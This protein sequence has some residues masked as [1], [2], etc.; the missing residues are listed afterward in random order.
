MKSTVLLTLLLAGCSSPTA[1]S[2]TTEAS[3][4]ASP[5]SDADHA[6]CGDGTRDPEE[7]CDDGNT[8]S[9]DGCSAE[10]REERVGW[11][12]RL[13]P[14]APPQRYGSA[15]AFDSTRNV[16]VLH[17]GDSDPGFFA[18]T[19]EWD[20]SAWQRRAIAGPGERRWH[21]MAYD[22]ARNRTVL[23]GGNGVPPL[24]TTWEFDGSQWTE[25]D[26]V[27]PAARWGH[28][29]V[30]DEQRSVVVLFGGFTPDDRATN[31][32]W[33]FDG[34]AWTRRTTPVAPPP[35]VYHAMTYDP[36]R[37][38]VV[39][40]GGSTDF[41]S[42]DFLADTWEYDGTSWVQVDAGEPPARAGAVLAFS[43]RLGGIV[44]A[45]GMVSDPRTWLLHEGVWSELAEVGSLPARTEAAVGYDAARDELVVFGGRLWFSPY[46]VLRDTWALGY[47]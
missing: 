41:G 47:P 11:Q 14:A 18:D 40:F 10:C 13:A 37:R 8:A 22:R 26:L 38:R 15:M 17:G 6:R 19:W 43:A 2:P 16:L 27:G 7:Q 46:T 1:G 31:E 32:T 36:V 42:F 44:M 20:G 45:G 21:A 5:A 29:M 3:L 12:E 30:Y 35:R 24:A 4:D 39:M 34:T 9:R 33:E 28:A 25:R 23:F